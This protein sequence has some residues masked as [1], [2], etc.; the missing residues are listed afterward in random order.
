MV[1]EIQ[2]WIWVSR[3][4]SFCAFLAHRRGVTGGWLNDG[5]RIQASGTQYVRRTGYEPGVD[6]FRRRGERCES[7]YNRKIAEFLRDGKEL[8]WRA[9]II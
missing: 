4:D 2:P 5:T 7:K 3:V 8:E 9:P 1:A 6:A